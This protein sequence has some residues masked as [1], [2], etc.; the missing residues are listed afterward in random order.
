MII[1]HSVECGSRGSVPKT[2][3]HFGPLWIWFS[4]I[5]GEDPH[6]VSHQVILTSFPLSAPDCSNLFQAKHL[7]FRVPKTHFN[8][9]LVI[10][11]PFLILSH[12]F[13]HSPKNPQTLHLAQGHWRAAPRS[14]AA[15]AETLQ[16][17][18]AGTGGTTFDAGGT[19][20][21]AERED[22]DEIMGKM[23]G[24]MKTTNEDWDIVP[25]LSYPS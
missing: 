15:R 12:F 11:N 8:C 17:I 18:G 7:H 16:A 23:E 5:P 13:P 6:F 25:T 4:R 19:E 3:I 24:K 21:R 10:P 9:P 1:N 2:W 22:G 14:A 20:G